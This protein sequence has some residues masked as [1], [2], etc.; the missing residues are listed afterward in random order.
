MTDRVDLK[1]DLIDNN[2]DCMIYC[3]TIEL[4]NLRAAFG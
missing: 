1:F 2:A 4:A 3:V